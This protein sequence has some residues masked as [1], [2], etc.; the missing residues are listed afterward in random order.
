[1]KTIKK[2]KNSTQNKSQTQRARAYK[3]TSFLITDCE[4][5]TET[6]S[7]NVCTIIVLATGQQELRMRPVKS[8]LKTSVY[9]LFCQ[10]LIIERCFRSIGHRHWS[11]KS[12]IHLFVNMTQQS[13]VCKQNRI[14]VFIIQNH[15]HNATLEHTCV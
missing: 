9:K 12:D 13:Q 10:I 5:S 14:E 15:T 11:F 6:C 2:K 3:V 1:M 4:S 8:R 7:K